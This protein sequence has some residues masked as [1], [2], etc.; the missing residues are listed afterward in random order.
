M[1]DPAYLAAAAVVSA[2][3]TWG[4]RALP[5]LFLAR[6]RRSAALAH[7]GEVLPLG[8]MTILVM[9]ALHDTRIF[10]LRESVPV[11]L[12]LAV[13]AGVHLWRGSPV[14]SLLSGTTVHVVLA[15]TLLAASG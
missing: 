2:A 13:T 3:V 14:L 12:A 5:F 15:S 4:L 10:D 1:P 6:L 7:L 8:M 9:Y 11:A